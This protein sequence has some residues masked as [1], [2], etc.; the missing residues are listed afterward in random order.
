MQYEST[1]RA[2]LAGAS[3]EAQV[4]KVGEITRIVKELL[5]D[6]FSDIYV[7]GEISNYHNHRS[8]GHRYFS[9]K[10]S[11]AALSC[12]MWRGSAQRLKFE[13]EDGMKVIA[14]GSLDVYEP[15]GTYQLI[16]KRLQ[17]VGVGEL[18]IAFRQLY[19]KL[20][21]EGLF[22]EDRKQELPNYPFTVGIVTSPT[23]AAI[24]DMINVF[25][26]RNSLMKLIIYPATVQGSG[27]ENEIAAGIDYFNTRDD[28]DLLI[29]GRGGGSL[30]DLW[31]FNTEV[32]VRALAESRIP[33]ISGVGHEVDTTLADYAADYRAPT[34]SAAAE[35]AAWELEPTIAG[36]RELSEGLA[37][38]LHGLLEEGR[39][40]LNAIL[41]RGVFANP[42]SLIQTRAQTLDIAD[43]RFALAV[44]N[45]F[46]GKR[47]ELALCAQRL[48]SLSPL[49]TLARGF[50]VARKY[51][52][53]TDQPGA[54]L[55]SSNSVKQGEMI[56]VII[57]KG[58]VISEV[59][60]VDP[61]GVG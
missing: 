13:P 37:H 44:K 36:V 11:N 6:N 56:E 8:S 14:L 57:Q 5:R 40:E 27:A 22:D 60:K 34:P 3:E 45:A 46:V 21:K 7:E 17:P 9:L 18:E 55:R 35:I 38:S 28:I 53:E 19:E 54:V 42:Q 30:E 16:V 47:N 61:K 49:K 41:R 51:D 43:S 26:R 24:R 25:T 52:S 10:D 1:N 2:S 4:F 32:V 23:G 58:R 48:D 33:T 20:T 15:R 31:C 12:A 39:E 29:T 59:V 50:A